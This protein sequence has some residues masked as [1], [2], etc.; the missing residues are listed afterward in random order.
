MDITV[1]RIA[2]REVGVGSLNTEIH[3]VSI[4]FS[5]GTQS[6]A[7]SPSHPHKGDT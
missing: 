1:D 3:G 4:P 6:R 5:G 7:R 2:I